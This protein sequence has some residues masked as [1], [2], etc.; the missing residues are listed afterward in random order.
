VDVDGDEMFNDLIRTQLILPYVQG[1]LNEGHLAE[2]AGG[3]LFPIE[4]PNNSIRPL[5]IGST[6]RRAPASLSVTKVNSDVASFL[7]STY[8]NFLQFAGQKDGTSRCPQVTQLLA[9]DWDVHNVDDPL[10][11]MQLDIIN[12]FC[13]VRRQARFDVLTEKA[14]MSYDN[15]NVRNGDMV[16]CAPSLHKYCG[17]FQSMQGHAS[18]LLFF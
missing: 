7:M 18:T 5:F 17:Y 4:N 3:K 6:W 16:P 14:S 10:V 11:I 9:S 1:G 8:D 2:A 12:A 15:G 13:S